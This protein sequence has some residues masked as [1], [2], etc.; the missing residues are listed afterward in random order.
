MNDI[1]GTYPVLEDGMSCDWSLL[2][3]VNKPVGWRAKLASWLDRQAS[4]L[5]GRIRVAIQIETS[6]PGLLS[7]A[8]KTE[9][10]GKAYP[11]ISR[12]L[13]TLTE[14]ECMDRALAEATPQFQDKK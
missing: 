4:K 9:C 6:P 8:Q 3:L 1:N 13:Q 7:Q 10:I 11:I 2:F 12:N 5:D 14:M